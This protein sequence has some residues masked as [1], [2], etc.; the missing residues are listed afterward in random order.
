M[1]EH[2]Y[3]VSPLAGYAGA[4]AATRGTGAELAELAFRTQLNIR[5]DP[6]G[7]AA[8]RVALALG[9]PLPAGPNTCTQAGALIICW[10]GPDEWLVLAEPDRAAELAAQVGDALGEE[11]GSVV[12]VSAHRTTIRLSGTHAADV[13]AHGCAL[14]LHP[15]VFGPG[16]CAQTL[17]A[18]AGVLLIADDGGAWRILVRSSFARYLADWLLDAAVEYHAQAAAPAGRAA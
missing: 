5:L 3:R 16:Q 2:C 1:A 4:F 17:L 9:V 15:R 14:D 7:P 11:F 8:D 12:D 18:R 6:K 13:L 10:L